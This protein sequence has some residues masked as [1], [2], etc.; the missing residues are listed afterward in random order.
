AA[1]TLWA[2]WR[3]SA[4]GLAGGVPAYPIWRV[5]QVLG[6]ALLVAAAVMAWEARLRPERAAGRAG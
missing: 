2:V 6:V 1:V 5:A 3:A 4:A